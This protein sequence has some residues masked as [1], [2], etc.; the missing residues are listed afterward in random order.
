MPRMTE[1]LRDMLENKVVRENGKQP[2]LLWLSGLR[3]GLR[4]ERS[5]V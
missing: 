4:T 3:A 5:L 1:R 2:W